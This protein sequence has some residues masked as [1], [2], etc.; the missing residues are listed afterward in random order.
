MLEVVKKV[1]CKNCGSNAVIKYGTYKDVQEYFCKNCQRK[2]KNDNLP[3]HT[4][5]SNQYVNAVLNMYYAGISTNK[6]RSALRDTYDYFPSKHSVFNWLERYSSLAS[7]QS[8]AE[9]PKVGSNWIVDETTIVTY[10]GIVTRI[11]DVLDIDTWYLLASEPLLQDS[12]YQLVLEQSIKKAGKS[13]K[14]VVTEKPAS[15]FLANPNNRPDD[16]VDFELRS[17]KEIK[18]DLEHFQNFVAERARVI[19]F[20]R[21]QE[22]LKLLIHGYQ[23]YHNYFKTDNTLNG[24]IP[25]EMAQTE[26]RLKSWTDLRAPQKQIQI[27]L[28]D[29]WSY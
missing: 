3:F 5:V 17:I 11:L 23:V 14:T 28:K 12:N 13:P 8:N 7:K 10:R 22:R 15:F 16:K 25:A 29:V 2:F 1:V 18:A 24:K 19:K 21:T 4:K 27:E 6:I 9:H 26:Y 20:L